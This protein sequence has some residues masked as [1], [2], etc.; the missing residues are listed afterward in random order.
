MVDIG[1]V[2]ME[3]M[4]RRYGEEEVARLMNEIM[5]NNAMM[6]KSQKQIIELQAM[7]EEKKRRQIEIRRREQERIREQEETDK[8]MEECRK[9]NEK[10]REER[11]EK[12]RV[13]EEWRRVEEM[14]VREERRAEKEWR[15]QERRERKR[16]ENR[17]KAMEERKCFGCRGFG[18]M[19]SHCR[20]RGGEELVQVSSNRFEV[21][22]VRAMQ[23]GEGS[24]K[25]VAKDRKEILREER[26]KR[27]VEGRQTKVERKEKLLREVTVKIGLKQEEEEEG[28]VMEALL[29]SSATGLV[30]SE[31]FAKK[32]RFK[33]TK[34]ERPVYVRN[35][36][37]TLNYVRPIVDTIEVEIFFK[38]HMERTSID[39]IGGQK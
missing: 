39:V 11:E 36:D 30:M 13:D 20:N 33:R 28:V 34:L 27:Q 17:R 10:E 19:A 37:G 9:R 23:K 3:E 14:R 8:W 4:M 31:E 16:E 7:V 18:H 25:E 38:G 26:E 24:G 15:Y 6:L 32:H 21:L 29:D 22:K 1:Q 35:V 12:K 2:D 5:K